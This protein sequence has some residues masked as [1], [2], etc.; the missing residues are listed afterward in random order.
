[1]QCRCPQVQQTPAD[2]APTDQAAYHKLQNI[3]PPTSRFHKQQTYTPTKPALNT[4]C[5][6]D[7]GENL[8][9]TPLPLPL[10]LLPPTDDP[11]SAD[12]SPCQAAASP[13]VLRLNLG[14]ALPGD[15]G[16]WSSR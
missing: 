12:P 1:M 16:T 7:S 3:N 14:S 13:A 4:L 6:N 8:P 2:T 9:P 5:L 10:P 15:W 11:A